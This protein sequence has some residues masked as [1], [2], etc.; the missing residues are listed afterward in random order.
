[1]VG[2]RQIV[3]VAEDKRLEERKGIVTFYL[4]SSDDHGKS[5]SLLCRLC[6]RHYSDTSPYGFDGTLLYPERVVALGPSDVIVLI[7]YGDGFQADN[8]T[9][10]VNI[11][12][13]DLNTKTAGS[14]RQFALY[15]KHVPSAISGCTMVAGKCL[16]VPRNTVA[17]E[18]IAYEWT[19]DA[20]GRVVGM[21]AYKRNIEH[22]RTL[23]YRCLGKYHFGPLLQDAIGPVGQ[24]GPSPRV[25]FQGDRYFLFSEKLDHLFT[26]TTVDSGVLRDGLT[27]AAKAL[28]EDLS[29]F[30]LDD[31]FFTDKACGFALGRVACGKTYLM[32]ATKDGGV[33]WQGR[34]LSPES[35][36]GALH[37]MWDQKSKSLWLA[38][39]AWLQSDGISG[40]CYSQD[41]GLSWVDA[42][43]AI[44]SAITKARNSGEIPE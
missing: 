16:S 25:T 20:K 8:E 29:F 44:T 4:L 39:Y 30:C 22:K 18:E 10:H 5:W 21:T 11:Q 42:L 14:I 32:F 12:S 34:R 2:E 41:G 6:S 35:A 33:T 19:R 28:G 24:G 23:S 17:G 7:Q 27:P 13:F 31:F 26:G 38:P 15:D 3:L 9:G 37:L 36:R 43:P 40:A 1:M